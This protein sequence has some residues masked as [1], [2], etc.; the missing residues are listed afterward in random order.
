MSEEPRMAPLRLSARLLPTLI[1]S[2]FAAIAALCG[3]SATGAGGGEIEPPFGLKWNESAVRLEESLLGA[4]A[5][6]TERHKAAGGREIWKVEGLPQI[7][8]QRALFHLREGLLVEIELQYWKDDWSPATYDEFMLSTRRRLEEKHGRGAS[9]ARQQ[10]T[11]HGVMKTL[12]GYRWQVGES[13]IELIYFSAQDPKNLFRTI[14]LHYKSP[15]A[16]PPAPAA[17]QL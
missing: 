15:T 8:L 12:V 6:I 14:S 7:A 2:A 5:K 3:P 11:E 17:P 9:I 4:N 1:L 13:A 16:N 10:D